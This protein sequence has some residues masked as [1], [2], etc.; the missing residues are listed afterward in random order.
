MGRDQVH[1]PS[2]DIRLTFVSPFASVYLAR[3]IHVNK[4]IYLLGYLSL[5]YTQYGVLSMHA[6]TSKA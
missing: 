4:N 6:Q 1:F 3:C 2:W 5:C